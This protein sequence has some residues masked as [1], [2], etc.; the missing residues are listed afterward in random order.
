MEELSTP[1]A[2]VA[3]KAYWEANLR[4]RI[5]PDGKL[6]TVTFGDGSHADY[7]WDQPITSSY[8]VNLVSGSCKG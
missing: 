2:N 8:A 7:R 4:P 5:T 1:Y 3:F 6:Y